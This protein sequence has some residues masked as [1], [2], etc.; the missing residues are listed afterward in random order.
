MCREER[1][2]REKKKK[3]EVDKNF[4]FFPFRKAGSEREKK[5]REKSPPLQLNHPRPNSQKLLLNSLNSSELI[6]AQQ[7]VFSLVINKFESWN[8]QVLLLC[9]NETFA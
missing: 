3:K 1:I 2:C 5:G 7:L 4:F 6:R 8:E 9:L